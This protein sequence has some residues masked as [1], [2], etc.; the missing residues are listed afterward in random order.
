MKSDECPLWSKSGFS[1]ELVRVAAPIFAFLLHKKTAPV[2][3]RVCA[4]IVE[5]GFMLPSLWEKT[6]ARTGAINATSSALT[7]NFLVNVQSVRFRRSFARRGFFLYAIIM[8]HR[9]ARYL[10]RYMSQSDIYW[11][12]I[13]AAGVA[14]AILYWIFVSLI[15]RKKTGK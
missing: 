8:R 4:V 3:A 14:I 12:E 11:A 7:N 9:R 2:R 10:K 1:S 13:I 5:E 15:E 6:A